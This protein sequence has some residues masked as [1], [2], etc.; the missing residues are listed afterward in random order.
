VP[1]IA[2]TAETLVAVAGGS[3]DSDDDRC[4]LHRRAELSSHESI[5]DVCD[6]TGRA[7][8]VGSPAANVGAAVSPTPR[9]T[10]PRRRTSRATR[11]RLP[12][13]PPLTRRGSLLHGSPVSLGANS[14]HCAPATA[15]IG[16]V[17]HPGA[18]SR[19]SPNGNQ[20]SNHDA[21]DPTR[22]CK[23]VKQ[24]PNRPPTRAAVGRLLRANHRLSAS[25]SRRR[26]TLDHA[27][28]LCRVENCAR[29]GYLVD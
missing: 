28:T 11:T 29:P 4:K 8:V 1:N 26:G 7:S 5:E 27:P 14:A 25:F 21:T 24:Q 23:G 20:L 10:R 22:S 17:G 12:V 18:A 6:Y 3:P 19:R 2:G 16:P 9:H 15:S 13:P